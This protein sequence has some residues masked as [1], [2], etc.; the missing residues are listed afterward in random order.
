M[1]SGCVDL[2]ELGVLGEADGRRAVKSH[3]ASPF[4]Q[5]R[6]WQPEGRNA[7]DGTGAAVRRAVRRDQARCLL[8][9]PESDGLVAE[10]RTGVR[11]LRRI[12]GK[13]RLVVGEDAI[14][15][16]RH[17]VDGRIVEEAVEVRAAAHVGGIG[18]AKAVVQP[19]RRLASRCCDGGRGL[20]AVK[21][22][23]QDR[24]VVSEDGVVPGVVGDLAKDY[25]GQIPDSDSNLAA[26]GDVDHFH[27]GV[28]PAGVECRLTKLCDQHA[29][30]AGVEPELDRH[31]RA[32]EQAEQVA[33]D[34]VAVRTVEVHRAVGVAGESAGLAQAVPAAVRGMLAGARGIA[35]GPA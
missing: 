1:S 29:W 28:M 24:A 7:G 4:V 35:R 11:R 9:P 22:S 16:Q 8:E 12:G 15:G 33:C 20:D 19:G 27:L 23:V 14:A 2:G 32:R 25:C 17:G 3:G 21:E 13:A 30:P 18:G 10:N 31:A 6:T 26:A 5:D 34:D